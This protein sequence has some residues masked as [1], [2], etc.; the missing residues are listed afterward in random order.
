MYQGVGSTLWQGTWNGVTDYTISGVANL[1]TGEGNGT[2]HETFNGRSAD[3][4]SGSLGFVETYVVDGSGHIRIDAR[5]V[6]SAGGFT[7][8]RGEVTFVG[9]QDGVATGNGTFAGTWIRPRHA[10]PGGLMPAR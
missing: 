6:R 3:G 7:G 10:P 5:I 9:T 1:V 2:I 8:S 4:T